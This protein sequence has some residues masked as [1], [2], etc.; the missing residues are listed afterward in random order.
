M[1]SIFRVTLRFIVVVSA[2]LAFIASPASAE[3]NAIAF[4]GVSYAG[5]ANTIKERF[6][7]SVKADN[8]DAGSHE[9]EGKLT[10]KAWQGLNSSP[11]QHFRIVTNFPNLKSNDQ[12]TALTLLISAERVLK[13]TYQLSGHTIFKVF[14]QVRAQ[15]LYFDLNKSALIRDIPISVAYISTFDHAPNDRDIQKGVDTVLF[16]QDGNHGLIG[17]FVAMT[18]NAPYPEANPRFLRVREVDVAEPAAQL[19]GLNSPEAMN[20]AR[21]SIADDFSETMAARNEISFI[22]YTVDYVVG[23]VLPL[24]LDDGSLYNI[25]MPPADYEFRMRLINVKKVEFG[26]SAAG[27]SYI[28]GALMAISLVQ[29]LS[30][31]TYLDSSFKNGVVVK[32]PT[33]EVEQGREDEFAFEDSI[34]AL[35]ERLSDAINSE[36]TKWSSVAASAQNINEQ[37]KATKELYKLCH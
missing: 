19:L 15:A 3:G 18:L 5:A 36:G 25:H 16:G 29:P 33:T 2:S 22:P 12:A 31:K 10:A 28:Y 23:A 1:D 24:A 6:P 27:A 35:F 37:L 21:S 20:D 7:F 30:G 4:L 17:K 32:V 8:I 9:K 14:T 11:P 13:S 26:Q 34:K